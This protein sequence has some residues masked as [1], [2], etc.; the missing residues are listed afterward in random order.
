[1]SPLLIPS[2]ARF[3][4]GGPSAIKLITDSKEVF[5]FSCF[6]FRNSLTTFL[7][8]FIAVL[9]KIFI[10]YLLSILQRIFFCYFSIEICTLSR[11]TLHCLVIHLNQP[12]PRPEARGPFKII[13]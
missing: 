11:A 4:Y 3:L 7:K 10:L 12:K 1:M 9:R 13:Q 6:S 5:F 2:A 8:C